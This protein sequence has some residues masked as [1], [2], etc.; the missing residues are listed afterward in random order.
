MCSLISLI[1]SIS[2]TGVINAPLRVHSALRCEGEHCAD[3]FIGEVSSYS[4]S[5]S[6]MSLPV[7]FLL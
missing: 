2:K 4:E 5:V 7:F 1:S 3:S 6:L